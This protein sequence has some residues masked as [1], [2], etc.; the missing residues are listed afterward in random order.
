[1]NDRKYKEQHR[2]DMIEHHM[3]K[4]KE[5][6]TWCIEEVMN[7]CK[8][9]HA[10][11]LILSDLR[12]KEDIQLF[13]KYTDFEPI[14]LRIDATDE[15]RKARGWDPNEKKDSLPTEID[16]DDY[17]NWTAVFDNSNIEKPVLLEWIRNT[18]SPR[19]FS[20]FDSI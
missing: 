8:E 9:Q 14:I 15:V 1:M 11:I 12:L 6:P 3:A 5:N 19:L 10:D 7:Q 2:I 13:K 18:V 20:L 4:S 17:R 16:M